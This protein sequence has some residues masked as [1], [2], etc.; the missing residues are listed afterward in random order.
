MKMKCN[1]KCYCGNSCVL[2]HET[3]DQRCDCVNNHKFCQE[4]C[5]KHADNSCAW[6]AQH[7]G[8]H[9]CFECA[10]ENINE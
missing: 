2:D 9:D 10:K 8:S 4:N 6:I 1:G 5:S 3:V 7:K